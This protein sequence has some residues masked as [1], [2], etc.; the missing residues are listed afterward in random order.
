KNRLQKEATTEGSQMPSTLQA[1]QNQ[2]KGITPEQ[3]QQAM[4]QAQQLKNQFQNMLSPNAQTALQQSIQQK[5]QGLSP[6]QKQQM[7]N[8]I[9]ALQESGLMGR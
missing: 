2:W 5:L 6:E 7:Q 3:K 1:L 8:Q 4:Q 9:K